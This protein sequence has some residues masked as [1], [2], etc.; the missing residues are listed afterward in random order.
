MGFWR[1]IDS[2]TVQGTIS[3]AA[4][5][6]SPVHGGLPL[7]SLHSQVPCL[8]NLTPFVLPV[9]YVRHP[10]YGGLLL[11][12][13]LFLIGFSSVTASIAHVLPVQATYGTP[14]TAGCC[15]AAWAWPS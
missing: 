10:M 6:R 13:P 3:E 7:R 12:S 11:G 15:W 14:C 5:V 8:H 4:G 2:R 1:V 9:Q